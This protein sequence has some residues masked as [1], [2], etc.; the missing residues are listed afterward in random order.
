MR[1]LFKYFIW[2][3]LLIACE[4]KQSTKLKEA[5]SCKYIRIENVN[6]NNPNHSIIVKANIDSFAWWNER[7]FTLN[8]LL[9]TSPIIGTTNFDELVIYNNEFSKKY[10]KAYFDT[11]NKFYSNLPICQKEILRIVSNFD[12]K[13]IAELNSIMTVAYE[14][15]AITREDKAKI[16][17]NDFIYC[18]TNLYDPIARKL[19]S[20]SVFTLRYYSSHWLKNKDVKKFYHEFTSCKL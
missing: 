10:T 7:Y 13:L 19:I 15:I 3:F 18:V 11:F 14:R 2:I 17:Y 20:A 16:Y 4:N 1:R 6:I 12:P 8:I 9:R 5:L